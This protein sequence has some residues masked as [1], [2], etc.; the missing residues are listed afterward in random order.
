MT[1]FVRDQNPA[2][3]RWLAEQHQ[4]L[5]EDVTA[6]LDIEAGLREILIPVQ[7]NAYV[8]KLREELDIEAG[9]AAILS[10]PPTEPRHDRTDA[11]SKARGAGESRALSE[12]KTPATAAAPGEVTAPGSRLDRDEEP[13]FSEVVDLS[14][15]GV[16][17]PGSFPSW[18]SVSPDIRWVIRTLVYRGLNDAC[19]AARYLKEKVLDE[20]LGLRLATSP[21]LDCKSI[22]LDFDK[23]LVIPEAL[24]RVSKSQNAIAKTIPAQHSDEIPSINKMLTHLEDLADFADHVAKLA[25]QVR[26][27]VDTGTKAT[28]PM[29]SSFAAE[30]T[31]ALWSHVS[32]LTR[33]LANQVIRV[34]GAFNDFTGADLIDLEIGTEELD[35]I[36]WSSQTRWPPHWQAEIELDSVPIGS[37]VYQVKKGVR[38]PASV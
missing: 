38:H 17:Q 23:W 18:Q 1:D 14:E 15:V 24:K 28:V 10:P 5:I 16:W 8:A 25:R 21:T 12:G 29:P 34:R 3:D 19:D 4:A 20:P 11:A 26:N 9:L 30:R 2:V 35:G 22:I 7:H 31:T 27:M 6:S 33:E 37:D 13:D 36:R 32:L